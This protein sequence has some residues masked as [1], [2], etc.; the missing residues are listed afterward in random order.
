MAFGA[1]A[2]AAVVTMPAFAGNLVTNG[3]FEDNFGAG[4]FNQALPGSAGGQNANHPGTT[5]DGWT[6]I[7][8]N[9]SFPDGYAFVF[10]NNDSFTMSNGHVGPASGSA[11]PSGFSTLPLWGNSRDASPDGNYFYGVDST[12]HPSAL[13]QEIG[14]LV[15]GHTYTLTFDYAA[16][17]QFDYNGNTIDMW[18]VTL[19]GQT[20][21]TT[22]IDL[23]SHRFS[24]WETE[25]VTFT[26]DGG[27]QNP[28]LL[29]FVNNGM[30]G[31]NAD[32][33]NCAPINPAASGGPPFSLL[34]GVSLTGS[35]PEPSTWAMMFIGF[36][37]LAYVGFRNRRRSAISI[38]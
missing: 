21:A 13:T 34:D 36:A 3:S 18:D 17:Q 23:P 28:G 22:H 20:I 2:I 26:Y 6:V 12:Y 25:S 24:G 10:K 32:F 7:G 19:G 15:V 35:A 33:K 8:T 11:N 14:D 5:A 31:C 9:S 1:A 38:A 30:G 16:A 29:S 27:G 37:G 4:Q